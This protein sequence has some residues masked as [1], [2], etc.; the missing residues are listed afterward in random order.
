MPVLPSGRRIEYSLDRFHALLGQIERD[1][2]LAIA[3]ALQDPDD[4][5]AVLDAVHFNPETGKPHF[6]GYVAAH[7][8]ARAADWNIADRNAL[9][10]WLDSDSA[11]LNRAEAIEDIKAMLHG[12]RTNLIPRSQSAYG[13]RSV[14]Q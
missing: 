10:A 7:W 5:L 6:A 14:A 13:H 3:D 4:L 1:H 11:R 12:T 2:A 8:Q 9:R